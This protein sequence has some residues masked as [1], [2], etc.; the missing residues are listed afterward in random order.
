[1]ERHS[2]RRA[3]AGATL[4]GAIAVL[5]ALPVSSGAGLLEDVQRGLQQTLEPVQRALA[6]V[7]EQLRRTLV[8]P[9]QQA[10]PAPAQT[11]GQGGYQPPAHG[12]NPHGQGS[13]VVVDLQPAP[14]RPLAGDP[15]GAGDS[16]QAREEIVLGRARGEQRADGR[17]HGH[18]TLV[19]LFGNELLG[20][21]TQ[22]GQTAAGPLDAVQTGILDAVCD[23]TTICLEVLRA[24]SA[25]TESGSSNRFAVAT[26]RV[27][28][29][30]SPL[31]AVSA[32]E[33]TGDIASD[34]ICQ[35]ASGT[36]LV[37]GVGLAGV[38]LADV[39]QSRTESRACSDGTAIQDN[40]SSV[41]GLAG[42]GIPLPAAGCADGTPDTAFTP[43][44]PLAAIV[45][46]ADDSAGNGEASA[47]AAVPYG[48]REALGVFALEAGGSSLVKAGTAAS[49][50]AAVAP[51]QPQ[52]PPDLPEC[53]D[54]ADN[55]GDGLVDMADPDCDSP[56]DDSE[57]GTVEPD[58][59]PDPDDGSD[60]DGGSGR[61]GDDGSGE[62]GVTGGGDG[63]G[64]ELPFTGAELLV[65]A[66]LGALTLAGGLGLRRATERWAGRSAA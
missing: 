3:T 8:P 54:G 53:S 18:I 28:A 19:A 45:C 12:A 56:S 14:D 27:G 47:Q 40:S 49:E 10:T 20:V 32:V 63:D 52:P 39:A 22:E 37:A 46:N 38:A 15:S 31:L 34:G 59:R 66:L 42:T 57:D 9:A 64:G 6:P 13:P 43:L 50:S 62:A 25:T 41:I 5:L 29:S 58:V 16:G 24:D 35:T 36:S 4:V 11:P 1:M 30:G 21:D 55:D 23:A 17:Y 26:A 2:R 51:S 65:I 61:D 48:V 7:E 33:S 44:A 60:G